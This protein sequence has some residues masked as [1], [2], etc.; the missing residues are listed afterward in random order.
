LH[1]SNCSVGW[2]GFQKFGLLLEQMQCVVTAA[3][4]VTVGIGDTETP[5]TG[6][7]ANC[8]TAQHDAFKP[9]LHARKI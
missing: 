8:N 7:L 4:V 9:D 2:A 5:V 6:L 1:G 3:R